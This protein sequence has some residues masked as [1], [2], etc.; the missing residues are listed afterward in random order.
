MLELVAATPL[1]AA[2]RAS[3]TAYLAVNA[4]HILGIAM[5]V[6]AILPLDLRLAGAFGRVPLAVIGPF[7]RNAAMLG[8]GLAVVTGTLL[9]TVNPT[10]YVANP[11]F[12][13][14]LA[15]LAL[16]IAN[17]ALAGHPALWSRAMETGAAPPMLR[18]LALL[19]AVLWPSVIL[20]GRWIGFL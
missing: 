17:A 6:G 13:I 9:F 1:A 8:A 12:R 3:G 11:A 15:L 18:A 16:A 5:L 10:E 7:L 14:K 2:L 4:A 19:S 20:A